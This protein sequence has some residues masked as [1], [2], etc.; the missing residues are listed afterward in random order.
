VGNGGR[1]IGTR[2]CAMDPQR[3]CSADMIEACLVGGPESQGARAQVVDMVFF[4]R[5]NTSVG[6]GVFTSTE[7]PFSSVG[8]RSENG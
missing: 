1:A 5:C 4:R 3:S 6:M 2:L 8:L 7:A